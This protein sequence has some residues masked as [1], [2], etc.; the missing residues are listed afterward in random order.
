[1]SAD[2]VDLR[3]AEPVG[4][5]RRR[6]VPSEP[7]PPVVRFAHMVQ[8][9]AN[10]PYHLSRFVE[11]QRNDYDSALAELRAGRKRSHWIWYIFPQLRG[12]GR[13]SRAEVYG[14]SDI[15][16]ARAYLAHPVLGPRLSESVAAAMAWAPRLTAA[17]LMG[18]LDA[19]KLRS[20]LTLF[21]AAAGAGSPFSH[22]LDALFKGARDHA[23]LRLLK[24]A[25]DSPA[26]PLLL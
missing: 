18:D 22:A 15:A 16:E 20:S 26:R 4:P 2:V 25:A 12:L 24:P 19:V 6:S 14:L 23:T 8:D 9:E 11:A 3:R 7:A 1:M 5:S 13:S 21:E 17:A 10:D